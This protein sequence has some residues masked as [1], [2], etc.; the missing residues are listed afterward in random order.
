MLRV[1]VE[2][3]IRCKVSFALFRRVYNTDVL[4]NMII[5]LEIIPLS[6]L[7][8]LLTCVHGLLSLLIDFFLYDVALLIQV[9]GPARSLENIHIK[10]A[11]KYGAI[12]LQHLAE[13]MLAALPPL[14]FIDSAISPVHLSVP[15][16]LVILVVAL[17]HVAG[18]P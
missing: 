4:H 8:R 11:L 14:A 5:V 9:I 17:V 7:F 6:I 3:L 12:R 16:P 15:V 2:L 13:A 10:V 18:L 1:L